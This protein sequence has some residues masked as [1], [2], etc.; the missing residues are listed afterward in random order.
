LTERFLGT[1]A[2][3]ADLSGVLG[4]VGFDDTD[5]VGAALW[6][7]CRGKAQSLGDRA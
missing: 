5:A 1:R 4:I 7:L 3:S 2:A 6:H